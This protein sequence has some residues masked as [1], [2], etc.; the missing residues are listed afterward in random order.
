M[1]LVV[2]PASRDGAHAEAPVVRALAAA[3]IRP[4]IERTREAGDG[5]RAARELAPS[6]DCLL[7]LGGDGTVMEAATGLADA[8]STAPLGILPGGTGNQ[9]AR[10]LS[11]PMSP[12]RAVARLLAGEA[13]AID[14]GLLN[15][16]RR[17]G[18]G[19]GL[20]LDAA[21][22]AGARG[23]LK[24]ILGVGSYVVSALRVAAR[25]RRFAV[26][27]EVDGRVIERECSVAMALNLGHMF[28]GMLEGAPGT[29]L[30]DGRLDLALL[31]ARHLADFLD[32][33]LTESLLRRRRPDPRWT[34]ASGRQIVLETQD[35]TVPAQVDGDL[36]P[37]ERFE[38]IVL[39]NA[40][41]LLV[42]AGGR[43]I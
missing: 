9:L 2:N 14:C 5:V 21:M 34:F 15:G 13:R 41:H 25:P 23:P 27:A 18:I 8:G 33:S 26:R 19:V 22:I 11:V 1:G 28:N 16:R 30:V 7:V 38:L 4:S 42:P 32:F 10:A 24:R 6:H 31:D 29:S 36:I 37:A 3:G 35:A 20:G 39:P 43:I 12:T 40:L 17:V